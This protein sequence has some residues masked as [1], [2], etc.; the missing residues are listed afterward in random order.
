MNNKKTTLFFAGVLSLIILSSLVSALTVTPASLTLTH[1]GDEETFVLNDFTGTV[2]LPSSYTF[3]ADQ[4]PATITFND[5]SVSAGETVKATLTS[6]DAEFSYSPFSFSYPVGNG[7]ENATLTLNVNKGYCDFG[8]QGKL[9]IRS[10]KIDNT[11]GYGDDEEWYPLDEIQLKVEVENNEDYELEDITVVWGIYNP[12]TGKWIID[13]EEKNFDL[14]DDERNTV[15]IN[16][17]IDPEDLDSNREDYVL[18]VKAYSD[19]S[20]VGESE[21]C[22]SES[23]TVKINLDS[24]FVILDD[25]KMTPEKALCGQEVQVTANV[26]NIGEDDQEDV[27]VV[28]YNKAL[29]I[30]EEIEVG[31]VDSLEK[32][33][34]SFVITVPE[35]TEET[36]YKL[37]FWVYDEDDQIYEND[38]D[39]E[40][41]EEAYLII[42]GGCILAPQASVSAVLE[43]GGQAGKELVI[44]ATIRNIGDKTQTYTLSAN[45]YATWATLTLI[46]PTTMTLDAGASQ[47][48]T[49]RLNVNKDVEGSNTFNVEI[50]TGNTEKETLRQSVQ[51]T[52]E[53]SSFSFPG[54]SGFAV[55]NDNWYLWGIGALNVILI[56]VIIIIAVRVARS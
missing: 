41:Y 45:N 54:L 30:N 7:T 52:I 5:T 44:K 37:Q 2:T 15:T 43:S 1:V 35:E 8:N 22:Y 27:Y 4:K 11:N 28:V 42:E 39:D 34:I 47:E 40:S 25:L 26:W 48:V 6:I 17:Q 13:D 23:E 14:D 18:Y 56:I 38:N 12:V 32:E 9:E 49:Y 55:S 50:K 31:D 19:D 16:F 53:K 10:L 21:Q 51:V 3:Y 20:D 24:D 33:K 36:S 46:D 29:G